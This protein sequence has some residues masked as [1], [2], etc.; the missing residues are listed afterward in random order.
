MTIS[1]DIKPGWTCLRDSR[2]LSYAMEIANKTLLFLPLN[3]EDGAS[4]WTPT[5][6]DFERELAAS[7]IKEFFVVRDANGDV[8]CDTTQ[9]EIP[10]SKQETKKE[11]RARS[12][13]FFMKQ[14]HLRHEAGSA[15]KYHR[16]L[17]ALVEDLERD[18]ERL[19]L[20]WLPSSGTLHRNLNKYPDLKTLTARFLI[21]RSGEGKRQHWHPRVANLLEQI[22][23]WY[24]EAS[25]SKRDYNDAYA[26]FDTRF[27]AL[28]DQLAGDASLLAPLKKPCDSTIRAYIDSAECYE[29]VKNK[30]GVQ[31]AED[32]F[33]G[34]KHPIE[35]TQLLDVV[36]IDS[37]ILDAWCCLDDETMLPLGRPTLTIAIDVFTRMILAV[38]VTFEPPSLFT[39]MSCLKRTNTPKHDI[40][41]RWPHIQ[42]VSDGWGKP[43]MIVVDNELA[44]IGKSFQ[45]ACE[46]AKIRVKWAPVKR[47][48]FKAVVER[49]FLTLKT[50]LLDK[51]P[52]GLPYKPEIMRQLGIEPKDVST[53][54]FSK[55]VELI[56][57]TVNDVYH[58][59]THSTIGRP[60][61]LAWEKSKQKS[62]RAFI[63]NSDFLEAAF[64]V[65]EEGTLTTSGI[66][67]NGMTFHEPAITGALLNDLRKDTPKRRRRGM[68][69]S[70]NP[71]VMFK[72]N[73]ANIE[74]IYVWNQ[75]RKQYIR[76]P[77]AAGEAAKGLSIWHWRILKIWAQQ[78]NILFVTPKEQLAARRR[79]RENIEATIPEEAYKAVKRQRRILYEP[80]EILEGKTVCVTT[81]TAT[82]GGMGPDDVEIAVSHH[83]PSGS[84][85][86]PK[87]PARGRRKSKKPSR[88]KSPRVEVDV[89]PSPQVPATSTREEGDLADMMI[90]IFAS[91]GKQHDDA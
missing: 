73:P 76:L 90:S 35:A 49:F 80:S 43:T 17:D 5:E 84:R 25:P 88:R 66:E 63:D 65:L 89:P 33:K 61:A 79:L 38:I 37:T 2:R 48:Q 60:P 21:S 18:A 31:A 75:K 46:D 22:I 12:L 83:A 1:L 23:D 85:I 39:A 45:S 6:E 7:K 13:F 14:W 28:A 44:Q 4:P 19:G 51:L 86:P 71:R 50:M 81:A 47:P 36:M 15:S 70:A 64:G 62:K 20:G 82:V 34:N 53:I 40:N 87:G 55:L 3:P 59:D 52:G 26:E 8:V 57:Q 78:E 42:R 32:Q 74:V 56:N 16:G 9:I 77:N 24:W 72:Y 54:T 91:R 10:P 41:E 27:D 69:S 67:F 58:Y 29:T 68:L 30:Y 11:N